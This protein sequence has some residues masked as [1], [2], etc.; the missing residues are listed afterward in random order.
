MHGTLLVIVVVVVLY[1]I[2]Y[3]FQA[4][5]GSTST[6]LACCGQVSVDR[7]RE[8]LSSIES[9]YS[10]DRI[11]SY[12]FTIMKNRICLHVANMIGSKYEHSHRR[13]RVRE[14]ERQGNETARGA[15]AGRGCRVWSRPVNFAGQTATSNATHPR[16][17][18]ERCICI[19]RA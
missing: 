10:T 12:T 1:T 11:K 8:L 9:C 3:L 5:M 16:M 4:I 18:S 19:F 6:G 13:W 2:F 15:V 7:S 17:T 14:L